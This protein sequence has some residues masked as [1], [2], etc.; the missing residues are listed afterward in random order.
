M[1]KIFIFCAILFLFFAFLF[2]GCGTMRDRGDNRVVA[3]EAV[4]I[5]PFYEDTFCFETF[6]ATSDEGIMIDG[7]RWASRNVATRGAFVE[8]ILDVG[9]LFTWNDAQLACPP[10]WRLPTPNEVLA[11]LHRNSF[12]TDSFDVEGALF[13]YG[14]FFPAGGFRDA[15]RELRDVGK[16]ALY[17]TLAHSTSP[18]TWTARSIWF[19]ADEAGFMTAGIAYQKSVR[20]VAI[21]EG[22]QV[23]YGQASNYRDAAERGNRVAQFDLA[24]SYRW[25]LG[26]DF[27]YERFVYWLRRSAER[28]F[29]AA[30]HYLAHS[31]FLGWGVDIDSERAVYWLRKAVEQGFAA[32]KYHLAHSYFF[33]LGVGVDYEASIY[34]LR[35]SAERGYVSGQHT[36]GSMYWRDGNYERAVYWLRKAIA[37]GSEG[38]KNLLD[39][40][41]E[42]LGVLIEGYLV[43]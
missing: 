36:L 20:C 19:D 5:I 25:G 39:E 16:V 38:A 8:T 3:D 28:G 10:G 22:E 23:G 30:K 40:L 27:D 42:E 35:Q 43:E 32:A 31:Y 17:W 4:V 15:Y 6:W 1:N 13:G 9:N 29:A 7:V 24:Q 2:S 21:T 26:V 11:L 12:W 41:K 14:L 37:Q 18:T 34:W 33:G